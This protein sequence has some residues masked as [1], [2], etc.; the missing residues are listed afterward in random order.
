MVNSNHRV[1]TLLAD[2]LHDQCLLL[3]KS[4]VKEVVPTSKNCLLKVV[5]FKVFYP[6]QVTTCLNFKRFSYLNESPKFHE[7]YFLTVISMQQ[8]HLEE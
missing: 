7:I 8:Q 1:P 5:S 2:F 6:S 4:L 3:F